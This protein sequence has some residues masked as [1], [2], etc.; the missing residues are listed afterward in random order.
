MVDQLHRARLAAAR[1]C[2]VRLDGLAGFV[3]WETPSP[4]PQK[5]SSPNV[6]GKPFID[7][8]IFPGGEVDATGFSPLW[9][10]Y[11]QVD[12]SR[13]PQSEEPRKQSRQNGAQKSDMEAGSPAGDTRYPSP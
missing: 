1:V 8:N 13:G 7:T 4:Y 12:S 9:R 11:R 5:I 6:R 10:A 2:P 3:F